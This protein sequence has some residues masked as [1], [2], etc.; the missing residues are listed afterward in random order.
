MNSLKPITI[1]VLIV[2]VMLSCTENN[3]KWHI[4]VSQCSEDIWRHKQNNELMIGGYV[5]NSVELEFL[6]ADDNDERQIEQINYFINEKVDLLIVS[7]NSVASIAPVIDKAFDNGIP[8][9]LFDR[10]TNSEKFT[11]YISADNYTIGNTMGKLIASN[12]NGIGTLVE[13]TGLKGSS[14]AIERHH[15]FVDAIAEYPQIKLV[16]SE[17]GDWTEESGRKA[18]NEVLTR[19]TNIDCVFG[20]NDRLALGARKAALNKG[21]NHIKYYGVD[22][23]P[24]PG[25]GIEQVQKGIFEATYIYPTQGLEVMRL[26]RKILNGEKF[27]RYNTL[28]SSVVDKSNA[29]LMLMQQREMA[30]AGNDIE[31]IHKKV[32]EYFTQV[33]IQQ[34]IIIAFIV[35]IV[36]IIILAILAYRFY[37]AKLIVHEEVAKEMVSPLANIVNSDESQMPVSDSFLDRFRTI[38]QQNLNDADFNVERIGEEMGMSR[39]QLYRK[40][41]SLTGMTP[42]ELLRKSRLARGKQILESS[43]RSVSEVAYE[44]GFTSPSYFAKCFKDEFGIT[45][46]DV[47]NSK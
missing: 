13:I 43:E 34:K 8:V 12:M 14:A 35:I 29:E 40:I 20:H 16:S 7:P 37:I 5:D 11:A 6:S 31:I 36:I 42:V 45:P 10:R 22:A 4:G 24:T 46:G 44:V 28:H 47:R 25:G 33:D 32:D 9:I 39:V 38:L 17:L 30:R 27:E 15:G 2:F 3:K 21:L 26:A 18:M 1:V 23:L 41:K 19:T